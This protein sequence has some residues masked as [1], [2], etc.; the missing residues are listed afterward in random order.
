MRE[1]QNSA[2]LGGL[3][4]LSGTGEQTMN[5]ERVALDV[6]QPGDRGAGHGPSSRGRIETG[7]GT[8][9]IGITIINGGIATDK[10]LGAGRVN[11]G[12]ES[13]GT[14]DVHINVASQERHSAGQSE[15]QGE[16]ERFFHILIIS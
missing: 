6:G 8:T 2:L 13:G 5:G 14:G 3:E 1:G 12:A 9:V 15:T 11:I 7:S 4:A 16:E 10:Q